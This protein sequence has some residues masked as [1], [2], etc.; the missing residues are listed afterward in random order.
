[1]R[2]DTIERNA[3]ITK[4]TFRFM[5]ENGYRIMFDGSHFVVYEIGLLAKDNPTSHKFKKREDAYYKALAL[6]AACSQLGKS[7]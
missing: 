4:A 1:M 7:K 5:Q 3:D 2:E 6:A